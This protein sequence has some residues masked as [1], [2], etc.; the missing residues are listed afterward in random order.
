MYKLLKEL[1]LM[2]ILAS[3]IVVIL[4]SVWIQYKYESYIANQ[5]TQ[6]SILDGRT[7]LV[8]KPA[9]KFYLERVI[10]G[11]D[12]L[13]PNTSLMLYPREY[14]DQ[15]HRIP[16]LD[17]YILQCYYT[18]QEIS[19]FLAQE[20]AVMDEADA[21]MRLYEECELAV[22]IRISLAELQF[23]TDE[24][25]KIAHLRDM[26]LSYHAHHA[27]MN[28]SCALMW[29]EK[30][31][32]DEKLFALFQDIRSINL[33]SEKFNGFEYL[34]A[35]RF[36]YAKNELVLA[37]LDKSL[38]YMALA[39]PEKFLVFIDG[40]ES[41][42]QRADF[43]RMPEWGI[44]DIATMSELVAKSKYNKMILEVFNAYPGRM[45]T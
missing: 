34:V 28:D 24:E 40:I 16:L 7:R 20:Q 21:R 14:I 38:A 17:E 8:N 30:W 19:E 1:V 18:Q 13:D 2:G 32:S 31:Y 43:L 15:T 5:R 12:S 35:I 22:E 26:A 11:K 23:A 45:N 10:M 41:D 6:Y 4:G 33:S 42:I 9:I 37:E 44:V 29:G 39:T 3:V 25:E 27:V 36:A